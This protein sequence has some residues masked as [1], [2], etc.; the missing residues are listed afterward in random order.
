MRIK[1]LLKEW[2]QQAGG[3]RTIEEY[4]VR[5]PLHDAAR[6]HALAE[7]YPGRSP[8]DI[9]TDLLSAALDELEGALPYVA[10]SRVIAEDDH[11]DPI[12]EDSG[13]T[14]RLLTLTRKYERM[15]AEKDKGK[16]RPS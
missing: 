8:D 4:A 12:Y 6:I 10:G 15:L 5:L 9:I 7:M 1:D 13:L 16:Q 11:D 2:E 14:P 3:K